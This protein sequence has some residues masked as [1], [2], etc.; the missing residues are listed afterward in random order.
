MFRSKSSKSS[1]GAAPSSSKSRQKLTS[2]SA[3]NFPSSNENVN[4]TGGEQKLPS[5]R[6][7]SALAAPIVNVTLSKPK[8][9]QSQQQPKQQ[10]GEKTTTSTQL[11]QQSMSSL[12]QS[13]GGTA[14]DAQSIKSGGSA[15]SKKDK[16]SSNS[17]LSLGKRLLLSARSSLKSNSSSL[18]ESKTK[19]HSASTNSL[20]NASVT[21]ASPSRSR[22]V[23]GDV[24]FRSK[25]RSSIVND[26]LLI[27]SNGYGVIQ[28]SNFILKSRSPARIVLNRGPSMSPCCSRR[29]SNTPTTSCVSH[30]VVST[31]AAAVNSHL[32]RRQVNPGGCELH[33]HVSPLLPPR[34][35]YYD[36]TE[37]ETE[38]DNERTKTRVIRYMLYSLLLFYL[39]ISSFFIIIKYM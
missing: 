5:I 4:G 30:P 33:P 31:A 16:S 27:D 36:T 19:M 2:A 15:A 20:T 18:S 8:K 35:D 26:N 32:S 10:Q 7:S 39:R 21:S 6:P 1:L 37:C 23:P 12:S 17:K 9:K 22:A 14:E 34:N 38:D 25:S 28:D 3:I 13:A 11:K 24:D 29:P